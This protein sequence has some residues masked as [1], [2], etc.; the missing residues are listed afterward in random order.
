M[1]RRHFLLWAVWLLVAP[2]VPSTLGG[3]TETAGTAA[4]QRAYEALDQE[5]DFAFHET[6]VAEVAAQIEATYNIPVHFDDSAALALNGLGRLLPVTFDVRQITLHSALTLITELYG[7]AWLIDD[8]AI[9]ITTEDQA[10]TTDCE[11]ARVYDVRDLVEDV[12]GLA[13]PEEG[14]DYDTLAEVIMMIDPT[15]WGEGTR[16]GHELDTAFPRHIRRAAIAARTGEDRIAP[17][18]TAHRPSR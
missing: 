15:S 1:C 3:E 2:A 10:Q 7:L 13:C 17:G 9:L 16:L 4:G 12:P 8:R 14:Y 5:G 18:H 6:P 11:Q